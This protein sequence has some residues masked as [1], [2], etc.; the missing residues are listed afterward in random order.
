MANDRHP[1]SPYLEQRW[2]FV[3]YAYIDLSNSILLFTYNKRLSK[4]GSSLA[5]TLPVPN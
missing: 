5:L 4:L 1:F 3:N 2:D